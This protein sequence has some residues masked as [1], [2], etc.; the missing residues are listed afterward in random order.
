MVCGRLV[1]GRTSDLNQPLLLVLT[2]T[3]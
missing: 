2:G 1:G 3:P